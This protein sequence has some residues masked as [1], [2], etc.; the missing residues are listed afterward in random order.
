MNAT[1]KTPWL[2]GKGETAHLWTDDELFIRFFPQFFWPTRS[3][4]R[5]NNSPRIRD[6]SMQLETLLNSQDLDNIPLDRQKC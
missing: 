2:G 6:I 3:Q 5:N 4:G 1:A